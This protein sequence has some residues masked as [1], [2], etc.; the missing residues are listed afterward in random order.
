[1]APHHPRTEPAGDPAAS[2]TKAL[3]ARAGAGSV[4]A[5]LAAP[6]HMEDQQIVALLARLLRERGIVAHLAEPRLLRWQDGRAHLN[7]AWHRG[8]VD[9]VVRFFQAEWCGTLPEECGWRHFFA[10][11]LTPVANA[12]AAVLTESKRFPLVWSKLRAPLTLWRELLPETRDPRDAPWRRDESWLLKQAYSNTGD[13]VC[14][15]A[16]MSP[17][18]WRRVAWEARL[19]PRR[20]VAQRRFTAAT[21]E[22]PLGLRF[23]CLGVYA[24]D[25]RADGIYARLSSGPVVNYGATDAAVL[26]EED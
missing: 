3:A 14:H 12:G 2:W 1:M 16:W 21:I 11:A 17:A 8:P 9:L 24:I 18:A 10:G 6:G 4:I 7:A 22:T 5:L 26:I 13:A 20:W 15:R 19:F 23:P 25:G